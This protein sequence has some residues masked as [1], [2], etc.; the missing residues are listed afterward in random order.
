[1]AKNVKNIA[2]AIVAMVSLSATAQ[3]NTFRGIRYENNSNLEWATK[4]HNEITI[5]P[6]ISGG[7]GGN[8]YGG[9]LMFR[10]QYKTLNWLAKAGVEYAEEN[11]TAL[12]N[13]GVGVGLRF[14]GNKTF[15][16]GIDAIGGMGQ[17]SEVISSSN[18]TNGDW[19]VYARAPFRPFAEGRFN[20]NAK[21]S[22]KIMLSA[23]AG[24]KHYFFGNSHAFTTEGQWQIDDVAQSENRWTAGLSLSI[25]L[26]QNQQLSGDNCWQAVAGGGYSNK[27]AV[28]LAGVDHFNRTAARGGNVWGFGTM[29][30]F[31]DGTTDQEVYAK[32]AY[33]FLPNGADSRVIFDLGLMAGIGSYRKTVEG[34]TTE[35]PNRFHH[36]NEL[37][38]FGGFGK[39][40]ASVNLHFN[41]FMIGVSGF[42]GG[43]ACVDTDF[44]YEN[45]SY[46]GSTKSDTGFVCGG[47]VT[48]TFSF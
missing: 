40:F 26:N 47:V 23:F 45:V 9:E 33:R 16:V 14:F 13:A 38:S 42:A 24:Y 10:R 12:A 4:T 37:S 18:P 6:T 8:A 30:T 29:L 2:I 21:L 22:K 7:D 44:S 5:S 41:R 48:A 11:K 36:Q 19:H 1:M 32:Y 31:D 46:D 25:L 3:E 35:D 15:S 28:A 43:N 17:A 27:G 39:A 34:A 20:I